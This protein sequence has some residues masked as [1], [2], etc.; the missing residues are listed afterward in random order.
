MAVDF[1]N[2]ILIKIIEFVG[3]SSAI[4]SIIKPDKYVYQTKD[5]FLINACIKCGILSDHWDP[6]F[7][8]RCF[9]NYNL[10]MDN[11]EYCCSTPGVTKKNT[12]VCRG[13][14]NSFKYYDPHFKIFSVAYDSCKRFSVVKVL[15]CNSGHRCIKQFEEMNDGHGFDWDHDMY[16]EAYYGDTDYWDT[17]I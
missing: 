4:N 12:I 17:E 7:K 5:K 9:N 11:C 10:I 8:E 15:G 6:L 16:L 1:P 13:C 3:C 2:E 14:K